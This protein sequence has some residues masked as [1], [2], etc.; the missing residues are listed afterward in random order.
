MKNDLR[1]RCLAG[2]SPEMRCEYCHDDWVP[3][4][5]LDHKAG[6]G[7]FHC[8]ALGRRMSG[9]ILY[10]YMIDNNF[11]PGF[12]VLCA[13]C[14]FVKKTMTDQQF[15]EKYPERVAVPKSRAKVQRVQINMTVKDLASFVDKLYTPLYEPEPEPV[16]QDPVDIGVLRGRPRSELSRLQLFMDIFKKLELETETKV[17]ERYVHDDKLILA[18][19][20][21]EKFTAD[22][23]RAYLVRLKREG[24]IYEP[25]PKRSART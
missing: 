3:G 25:L 19:V 24:V 16:Y 7:R 15:R 9:N 6:N 23:A 8:D 20:A 18:L 10:K 17:G 1:L 2:Y 22:D 11:P 14:N 4:L 13:S 21:T 5:Q 12:Q